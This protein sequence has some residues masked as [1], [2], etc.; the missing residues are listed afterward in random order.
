MRKFIRVVKTPLTL[1]VLA[2]LVAFGAM[3]GWRN[4]T[5]AMPPRA[6][7]PCVLTELPGNKLTPHYV[8]IRTLNAGLRGGLAKRVS[9]ELRASGFFVLKVNNSE[10]RFTQTV[11]VGN[12]ADDPEVKLVAGFFKSAK[13]EGDGRPDH[14]VDVLL[15]DDYTGTKLDPQKSIS[16][17]GPVCLPEL[18]SSVASTLP[19]ATPSPTATKKK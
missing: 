12:S 2:G 19:K 13:R 15:G 14:I 1:L 4:A 16:V 7:D 10:Q 18:P 3:W 8:T 6:A 9:T 11:I 17:D 5:A